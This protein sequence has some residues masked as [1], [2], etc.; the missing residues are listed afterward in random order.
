M[1]QYFRAVLENKNSRK[2][3]KEADLGWVEENCV[4]GNSRKKKLRKELP[5]QKKKSSLSWMDKS[6]T[7]R[8]ANG[9]SDGSQRRPP[10]LGQIKK[11]LVIGGRHK[12]KES[13]EGGTGTNITGSLCLE[14]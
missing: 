13:N 9:T 1:V 6:K 8:R 4:T 3:P 7:R 2:D 10:G 12:G 14:L 11:G 5:V